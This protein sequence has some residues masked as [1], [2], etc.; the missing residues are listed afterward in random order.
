MGVRQGEVS[1]LLG[2][3]PRERRGCLGERRRSKMGVQAA[4]RGR[5][6]TMKRRCEARGCLG[7]ETADDWRQETASHL[8]K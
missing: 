7:G 4:S 5:V 8:V 2:P 1:L 6:R 3:N